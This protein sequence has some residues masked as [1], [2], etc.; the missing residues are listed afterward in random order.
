MRLETVLDQY[1]RSGEIVA[2]SKIANRLKRSKSGRR[3]TLTATTFTPAV[4][5]QL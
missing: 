5:P 4:L 3:F 1:H 2:G